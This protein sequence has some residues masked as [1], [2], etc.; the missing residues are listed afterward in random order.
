MKY[1]LFFTFMLSIFLSPAFVSAKQYGTTD[2]GKR[3]VLNDNSKW[4]Y[5]KTIKAKDAPFGFR[6]TNW[7]MTK[8]QVKKAEESPVVFEGWNDTDDATIIYYKEKVFLFECFIT[9]IF[10]Q[11]KLVKGRY[12][13]DPN[14]GNDNEYFPDF[15]TISAAL[16]AKYGDAIEDSILWSDSSYVEE[17]KKWGLALR[18]GKLEILR[19]WETKK[20]IITL[21]LFS[22]EDNITFQ[23][24][25]RD[26][27]Y[28]L[29]N[30]L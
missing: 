28:E 2:S 23:A 4:A 21:S 3:I 10:K 9:Y 5:V 17:P 8:E 26:K 12:S 25:Y 11:E 13:F 14:N 6:K 20:T 15:D 30:E 18:E 7:G 27:K 19:T 16:T 22:L 24:E 1:F 29:D